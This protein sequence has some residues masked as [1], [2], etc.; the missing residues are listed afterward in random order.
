MSSVPAARRFL[1]ETLCRYGTQTERVTG[2]E[3]VASA[4]LMVS[5]LVTNAVRHTQ[6]LLLLEI[7][8]HGETLHVAVVDD[9]PGSPIL[10]NPTL[11][12]QDHYATNGRGLT[13]VDVLAD[14][15][16]FTSGDGCKTVWFEVALP[17]PTLTS[18]RP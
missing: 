14:R 1:R 3:S 7:T 18:S 16:G 5:E 6:G 8:I 4:A 11:R 2:A 15:W 13:M 9:A 12:N 10:P 17:D